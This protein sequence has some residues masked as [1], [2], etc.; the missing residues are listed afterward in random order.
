VSKSIEPDKKP[1]LAVAFLIRDKVGTDPV[2][3]IVLVFSILKIV[4][5]LLD[6]LLAI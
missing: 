5:A 4:L 1:A 3:L 2:V 6:G